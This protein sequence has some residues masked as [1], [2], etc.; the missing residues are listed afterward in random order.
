VTAADRSEI[1]AW[2]SGRLI[3]VDKIE[4]H[5]RGLKHPAVSVFVTDGDRILIQRRAL[6]KYHTPG[7]WA[8]TCCTHPRWG[9]ELAACAVRRL[10]EELGI[11][12]L[13]PEPTG[14]VEYRADVGGGMVEHELVDVFLAHAPHGID[15]RPDPAE[16]MA[17][18][19]VGLTALI[20][21][22]TAAP[23]R[24]TPWLR[25]YLSDHRE[26][27]FGPARSG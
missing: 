17:V 18:R 20:A 14:R 8:N 3:P 15:V 11:A 24:F 1:P 4:V 16:V 12:G 2:V 6:A 25:L 26:T 9:E 13:A 27:I 7:L 19:W 23:G 22:I 21:E 10:G 5:R